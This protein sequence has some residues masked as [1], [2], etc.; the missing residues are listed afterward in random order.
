ML[1][2][3]T[4]ALFNILIIIF[5]CICALHANLVPTEARRGCELPLGLVLEMVVR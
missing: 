3:V 4:V 2:T 5:I 1:K